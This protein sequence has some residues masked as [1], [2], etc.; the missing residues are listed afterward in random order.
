MRY[1][2]RFRSAPIRKNATKLANY[3]ARGAAV[4]VDSVGQEP[5]ERQIQQ[6]EAAAAHAGET[7]MHSVVLTENYDPETLVEWG[8]AAAKDALDNEGDWMVGVH[9]DNDGNNHIHVGQ[10][11]PEDRGTDFDIGKV[12]ESLEQHVDD[13]PA[14]E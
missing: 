6:F 1:H 8:H 11:H 4:V 10:Y 9:T 14:W 2:C 12:R 13:P 7:R 3:V 5:S